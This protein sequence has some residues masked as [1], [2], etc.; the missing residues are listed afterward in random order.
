[1]AVLSHFAAV[2]S[3]P[4]Y[5]G[6]VVVHIFVTGANGHIGSAV[7]TDLLNAGHT[8]LGLARSERSAAVVEGLGAEVLRGDVSDLDLVHD[9]AERTNGTI[10]LAFDNQAAWAGDLAG[11]TE[12]DLIVAE[13]FGD[14]LAGSDKPFLAVGIGPTG[15]EQVNAVIAQN[16]RAA[17]PRV[18]AGFSHRGIGSA[19]IAIPPVVHSPRDQIGFIPTLINIARNTG[20]SAYIAEG[21]NCWPTVHTLDLSR[22]FCLAIEHAPAG[23]Q[24]WGAAEDTITTREIAETIGRHLELPASS[25]SEE[26]AESHFGGFAPIMALDFPTMTS[27]ET[28]QQLNWKPSHA[29]LIDDLDSGYYFTQVST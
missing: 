9:A 21:A 5:T 18:I 22:L 2:L 25:I 19:L 3:P 17:V 29:G 4:P 20:V 26:Q 28:Q 7:V 14:A 27:P 8:V 24:L 12:S 13:A 11:A 6:E 15:D 23:A 1:L 10:H 16:P